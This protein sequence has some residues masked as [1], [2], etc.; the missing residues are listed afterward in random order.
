[1][2]SEAEI[3]LPVCVVAPAAF[4]ALL[5][6]FWWVCWCRGKGL[7]SGGE[8]EPQDVPVPL[9]T[10]LTAGTCALPQSLAKAQFAAFDLHVG[11]GAVLGGKV[12]SSGV[13]VM[14]TCVRIV[15]ESLFR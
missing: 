2:E 10:S 13:R 11:D 6:C 8:G 1:M 5:T 4:E 3:I 14:F 9:F 12:V 7:G 15:L